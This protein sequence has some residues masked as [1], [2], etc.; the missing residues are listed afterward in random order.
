[1]HVNEKLCNYSKSQNALFVRK[2]ASWKA[3]RRRKL[4]KDSHHGRQF[5]A[6]RQLCLSSYLCQ[7]SVT[8]LKSHGP[9]DSRLILE[10]LLLERFQ[11]YVMMLITKWLRELNLYLLIFFNVFVCNSWS[12]YQLSVPNLYS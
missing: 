8:P 11:N 9:I 12:E 7:L 6:F 3:E 4:A 1:M 10:T 2:G 5:P